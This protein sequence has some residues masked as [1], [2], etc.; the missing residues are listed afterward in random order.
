M[1][2]LPL[3]VTFYEL[4]RDKVVGVT[5][6]VLFEQE[7]AKPGSA[8]PGQRVEEDRSVN[9]NSFPAKIVL[10]SWYERHKHVYPQNKWVTYEPGKTQY[11]SA[12][13]AGQM[14][15]CHRF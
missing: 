15:K 2:I 5:G 4:V 14:Y 7:A 3:N 13:D 1:G 8:A 9:P 11:S 10:R 12:R 6:N